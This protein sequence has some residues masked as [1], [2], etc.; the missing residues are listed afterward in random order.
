MALLVWLLIPFGMGIK[1]S[2]YNE[3]TKNFSNDEEI[4]K[5]GQQVAMGTLFSYI[6]NTLIMI[7]FVIYISLL[8]HKLKYGYIF[9]ISWIILFIAFSAVPF[10]RGTQ[11]L[12]QIQIVFGGII[13]AITIS[14]VIH[15]IWITVQFYIQRKF[16]YYELYK[17][18]KG[19]SK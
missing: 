6:G 10:L 4:S 5:L 13:S 7:F 19:R 14:I 8:R 15:L 16:H 2:D 1:T 12:P 18:H 17:I 11:Y 3:L 9:L